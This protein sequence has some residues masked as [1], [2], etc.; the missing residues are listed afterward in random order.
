MLVLMS[1]GVL[2][3]VY[4]ALR[5]LLANTLPLAGVMAGIAL[6]IAIVRVRSRPRRSR[7]GDRSG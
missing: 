4:V 6:V 5:L 1:L 3:V 7:D 2:D